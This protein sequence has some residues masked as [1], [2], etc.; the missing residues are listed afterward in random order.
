MS[1]EIAMETYSPYGTKIEED[2]PKPEVIAGN[3]VINRK[4]REEK[5]GKTYYKL[6]ISNVYY[7][8]WVNNEVI[9]KI[10]SNINAGD[11]VE[12][13]WTG[14]AVGDKM[15]RNIRRM[16]KIGGSAKLNE[17]GEEEPNSKEEGYLFGMAMNN[18]ATLIASTIGWTMEEFEKNIGTPL[19]KSIEKKLY[20]NYKEQRKELS[21]GNGTDNN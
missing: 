12:F 7:T 5:N 19:W 6:T 20:E 4:T 15:Y 8:F 14:K 9:D 1:E 16:N 10:M 18:A 13:T 11:Q 3:G 17:F 21:N 2:K